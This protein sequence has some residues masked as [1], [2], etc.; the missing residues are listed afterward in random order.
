MKGRLSK[1]DLQIKQ[2]VADNAEKEGPGLTNLFQDV[3]VYID[4]YTEPSSDIL[5]EIV[6]TGGGKSIHWFGK[7][8]VTHVVALS[9]ARTKI[10]QWQGIKIVKPSWIVDSDKEGKLL[11]WEEYRLFDEDKTGTIEEAFRK[12]ESKTISPKKAGDD[13]FISEFY[14]NSRLHHLS[15]WRVKLRGYVADRKKQNSTNVFPA[16][17]KLLA[18]NNKLSS[19]ISESS[20]Q[21][22]IMHIDLDCFFVSVGLLSR[23]DLKGKPVVVTHSHGK[24]TNSPG[25][26]ETKSYSEI[27]C[28]SYEARSMGVKNGMLLGHA[29]E[30]CPNLAHISYEFDKYDEISHKFY[31]VLLRYTNDIEPVSCD[32]AFVDLTGVI[33]ALNGIISVPTIISTIRQDILLETGCTCSAGVGRNRLVARLCTKRAK[34]NSQF[35]LKGLELDDFMAKQMISDLPGVG[36]VMVS[37]I[38]G[39]FGD[40]VITCG[41]LQKIS[42]GHLSN[43]FGPKT[44]QFL[45]D[46]A[47][48]VTKESGLKAVEIRKSVSA[49]INYGFVLFFLLQVLANNF[50]VE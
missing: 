46:A 23:P 3:S 30:L 19:Q 36:H 48:G 50:F 29:K 33:K 49:E 28:C 13:G 43:V 6:V 16:I 24:K 7:T 39:N 37:K 1:M 18:I 4:G 11:P 26:K 20:N 21:A 31:D 9:L 8:K 17:D 2:R 10:Q 35:I 42:L 32:E 27:A 5:R 34:P 47:R 14:G 15:D 45:F 40:D 44:G 22:Y 25:G 38:E 12:E 41:D